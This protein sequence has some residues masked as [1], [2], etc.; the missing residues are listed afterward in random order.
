MQF[1]YQNGEIVEIQLKLNKNA[2]F[3]RNLDKI[4][5]LILGVDFL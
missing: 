3:D 5:F 1:L 2:S 4:P